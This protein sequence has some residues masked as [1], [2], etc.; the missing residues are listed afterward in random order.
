MMLRYHW[1]LGVGHTYSHA[2]SSYDEN[3]TV[4]EDRSALQAVSSPPM[5]VSSQD[6]DHVGGSDNPIDSE[7]EDM[8]PQWDGSAEVE[9]EWEVEST[10]SESSEEEEDL[11]ALYD[12]DDGV[13]SD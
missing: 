9:L 3:R 8:L 11:Y 10:D 12:S 7:S 2:L 6:Q 4:T 1:G 13:D 5:Q